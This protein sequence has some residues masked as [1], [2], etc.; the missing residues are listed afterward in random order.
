MRLGTTGKTT[1]KELLRGRAGAVSADWPLAALIGLGPNR[2]EGL[3]A[4]DRRTEREP[5]P[6]ILSENP[7]IAAVDRL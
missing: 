2:S 4:T 6:R 5:S 7:C 3:T 1:G